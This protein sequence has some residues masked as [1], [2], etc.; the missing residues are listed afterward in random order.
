M[1]ALTGT[2]LAF[3]IKD[4]N[5]RPCHGQR[6]IPDGEVFTAPVRDS[7]NGVIQFNCE[8]LYRG[9]VFNAIKLE[10]KHGKIVSGLADS[11]VRM[12]VQP[13]CNR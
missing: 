13:S 11:S 10:F 6:N 8:T 5:V 12:A 1:A 7:V 2:D 9:T 4:M 3:S